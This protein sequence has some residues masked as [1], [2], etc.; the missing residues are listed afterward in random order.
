MV[1]TYTVDFII[2]FK[3]FE[4]FG[5]LTASNRQICEY[6]YSKTAIRPLVGQKPIAQ[7]RLM[8]TI[9]ISIHGLIPRVLVSLAPILLSAAAPA[10]VVNAIYNSASDVPITANISRFVPHLFD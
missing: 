7:L 3:K 1:N 4:R 6:R 9:A 10:G 5:S 8:K 2:F